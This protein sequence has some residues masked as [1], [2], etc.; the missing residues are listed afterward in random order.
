MMM[1]NTVLLSILMFTLLASCEKRDSKRVEYIATDAV[2]A[3][4]ITYKNDAGALVSE[5]I[6]ACSAEDKWKHSFMAE[7]GEI[8]YFSGSYK[9]IGSALKLMVL[10]D[11]K[12]YKQA[13]SRG[14]T[15]GWVTVSGVVPY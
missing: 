9:D 7:Q 2:S 4:A 3:Y 8:V 6:D 13:T 1:K 11:G 15:V 12:V 5:T 14:D 10:I